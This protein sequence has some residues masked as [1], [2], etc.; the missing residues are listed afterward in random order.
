MAGVDAGKLTAEHA[1]GA[2]KREEEKES[3]LLFLCVLGVLRG[4][5]FFPDPRPPIPR[6]L[7]YPRFALPARCL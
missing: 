4:E 2:E 7:L 5:F 6:A 3:L 1:E